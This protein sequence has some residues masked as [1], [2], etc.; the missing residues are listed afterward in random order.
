[1]ITLVFYSQDSTPHQCNEGEQLVMVYTG[2]GDLKSITTV[3]RNKR[4]VTATVRKAGTY[5][6]RFVLAGTDIGERTQIC[7]APGQPD[8]KH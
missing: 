8:F 3:D 1:M 4:I 2:P 5:E 7:I 6:V